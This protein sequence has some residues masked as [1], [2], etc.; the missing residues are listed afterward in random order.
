M[1]MGDFLTLRQRKLPIK[2]I[3][4]DNG[5]LGFVELEMKA[6]G[7]LEMATELDNPNFASMAEAIGIRGLR[8]NE[9]RELRP[10][11]EEAFRTD[12]PVLVD[13]KVNRLELSMPPRIELEQAK[14]F[15][16]FA[17]R[18]VINGGGRE[19]VD[20]ATTNLWR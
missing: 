14:G 11:L 2:T 16:L 4:F 18:T 8:V 10:A 20:L 9:P 5:A 1:L 19:L 13:V 12:G 3:I 17:L 7:L 15:G 6:A